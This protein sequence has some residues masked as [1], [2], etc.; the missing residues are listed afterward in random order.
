MASQNSCSYKELRVITKTT[1]Y[2]VTTC[3]QA[4]RARVKGQTSKIPRE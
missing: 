2:F 4:Q 3:I 1:L